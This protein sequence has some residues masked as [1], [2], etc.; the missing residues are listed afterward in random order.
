[1]VRFKL[2]QI[3]EIE[4]E[5]QPL[6]AEGWQ[7]LS[8]SY[9]DSIFCYNVQLYRDLA[10]NGFLRIFTARDDGVMFGYVIVMLIPHPHRTDDLVAVVDAFYVQP[11]Y[12]P[13]GTALRF[14]RYVENTIVDDGARI[15]TV[16]TQDAILGR[17]LRSCAHYREA[18]TAFE[19]RL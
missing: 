14:L 10:A 16:A 2:E 4:D 19:R 5:I 1:V 15:I 6:L 9:P 8:E 3:D 13:G 18:D 7:T 12:R 11:P 17:W